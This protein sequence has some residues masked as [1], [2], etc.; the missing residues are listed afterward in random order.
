MT[1][2][3]NREG[4]RKAFRHLTRNYRR[5]DAYNMG[6]LARAEERKRSAG[7]SDNPLGEVE[8]RSDSD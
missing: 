8:H 6:R 2:G 1:N 5:I 3:E 4:L 7:L